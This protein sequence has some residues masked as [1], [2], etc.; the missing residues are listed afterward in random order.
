MKTLLETFLTH[1]SLSCKLG[2]ITS[3]SSIPHTVKLCGFFVP[4]LNGYQSFSL[5]CNWFMRRNKA[6]LHPRANK[7]SRLLAVIATSS[8]TLL[9]AFGVA[10][11]FLT[12]L[13]QLP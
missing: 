13:E 3:N 7:A 10:G 8:T 4:T 5:W 12:K 9:N 6:G 1:S 2:G 11:Q